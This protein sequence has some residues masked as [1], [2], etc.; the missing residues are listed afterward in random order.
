ML[1]E[2]S[3]EASLVVALVEPPATQRVLLVV[4]KVERDAQ[5]FL[6]CAHYAFARHGHYRLL[7]SRRLKTITVPFSTTG[8]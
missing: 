7:V 8:W 5:P 1:A 4:F 6:Y 3:A 2:T